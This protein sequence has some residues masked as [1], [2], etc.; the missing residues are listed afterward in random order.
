MRDK[1]AIVAVCVTTACAAGDGQFGGLPTVGLSGNGG[2]TGG[3]ESADDA[4]VGPSDDDAPAGSSES[5]DPS[6]TSTGTG[7]GEPPPIDCESDA[8]C[9]DGDPCTVGTCGDALCSYAPI[10]CDDTLDCTMDSCE[11]GAC[12]H[13]PD[14]SVCADADLCNGDELCSTSAGCIA[15][16]PVTCDDGEACTVDE[17]NP[18]TG[19]CDYP[20]V[21]TCVGA[22]SCCPLG[23]SVQADNDCVCTNLAGTATPSSNGGGLNSTG[24][25]PDNWIDGVDQAGCEASSCTQCYG[26]VTSSP[27]V[28]GSYLQL[29]WAASQTIGSIYVDTDGCDT[30]QRHLYSGSVQYWNGAAW[31]TETTWNAANGDLAFD[32]NPP[33]E[34]TMLRLMDVQP[35]PGSGINSLVFEWYVYT[36]LG[37]TP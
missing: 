34:T 3:G 33:L 7:T 4:E 5:A 1:L 9:N 12:I 8:D 20:E 2:T 28:N 32:F 30:D 18:A 37:C 27:G 13:T 21:T 14:D 24:Y 31:I 15:G 35:P 6:T 19:T 17:C 29:T 36:P 10:D 16:T 22:D 26:W 25:G 23:C 11:G